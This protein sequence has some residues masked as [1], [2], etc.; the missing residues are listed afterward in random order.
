MLLCSVKNNISLLLCGVFLLLFVPFAHSQRENFPALIN[1][2][3]PAVVTIVVFGSGEKPIRQGTGFFVNNNGHV[4]TNRHVIEGAQQAKI[5]TSE[6]KEYI[7]NKILAVDTSADLAR[8]RIDSND[9]TPSLKLNTSVPKVGERVLIVGS[10]KGLE[11][12][13]SEGII[14]AVREVPGIGLVYQTTAPISP[15]SS[16]SPVISMKGDVLGVATLQ[17]KDAQNLNFAIPSTRVLTLQPIGERLL[18]EWSTGLSR[19]QIRQAFELAQEGLIQYAAGNCQEALRFLDRSITINDKNPLVWSTIGDCSRQLQQF[20][21]AVSAYSKAV[22]L[23]ED[24]AITYTRLGRSYIGANNFDQAIVAFT[25]AIKSDPSSADGYE[26]LCIAYNGV[27]LEQETVQ[28]CTRSIA[29]DPKR[30]LPY[31]MLADLHVK[32]K[33]YD[34]AISYLKRAV[35]LNPKD[36][37][38]RSQLIQLY[39]VKLDLPSAH[40]EYTALKEISPEAARTFESGLRYLENRGRYQ[41]NQ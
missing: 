27:G 22:S 40:R 34:S 14:S 17:V 39:F 33:Q 36:T 37:R 4:I 3:R 20:D 6:G 10:P 35:E 28:T 15:G 5:I 29:L 11:Q 31:T 18:I 1:Q 13:V 2:T 30:T 9:Q 21:R 19:E 16:G 8:I 23:G 12:T 38:V 32:K 41:G 7:A 24:G 26:G 25:N